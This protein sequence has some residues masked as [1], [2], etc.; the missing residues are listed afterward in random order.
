MNTTVKMDK[1]GRV[2]LPKA[3]RDGL[4]IA[5][6]DALELTVDGERVTLRPKRMA[7][8]LRKERGVWVFHTDEPLSTDTADAATQ[9]GRVRHG[10]AAGIG[11]A[12]GAVYDAL[13]GAGALKSGAETIYTWNIRDFLRL[14]PQAAERVARPG[15]E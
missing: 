6:G 9:A 8:P 2:V 7:A 15:P 12:G 3:V 1:A 13:L 4:H 10:D 11:L 5:P 14:T